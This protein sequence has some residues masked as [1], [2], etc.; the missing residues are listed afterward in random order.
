M[1]QIKRTRVWGAASRPGVGRAR[2]PG[3]PTQLFVCPLGCQQAQ[4]NAGE[5]GAKRACR[6]VR[7]AVRTVVLCCKACGLNFSLTWHQLA[8]A[9]LQRNPGS[10]EDAEG[11]GAWLERMAEAAGET[12][13]RAAGRPPA[14]R[15]AGR[16][17]RGA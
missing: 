14:G 7:T 6:V 15:L 12:R 17:L 11:L 2:L 3:F 4:P 13:G 8:R 10:L 5:P 16:Q 9:Y 1:R